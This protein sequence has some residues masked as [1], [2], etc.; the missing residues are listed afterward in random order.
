MP[1][2][3]TI[4]VE[5]AVE[6]PAEPGQTAHVILR[7]RDHGIGMDEQTRDR[8]FDPFFTTKSGPGAGLG[9]AAV[10]GTITQSG[11]TVDVESTPGVGSTFTVRLPTER[12]DL[13][14]ED[15]CG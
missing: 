11:G 10:H 12:G 14:G 4:V 7:V 5:T 15:G 8:V 13:T 9:L 2:G 1:G 3:G 6:S